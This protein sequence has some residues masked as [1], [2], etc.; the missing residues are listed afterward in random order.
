MTSDELNKRVKGLVEK[1]FKAGFECGMVEAID[2]RHDKTRDRL[3]FTYFREELAHK[4]W[5][6]MKNSF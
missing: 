1:A 3:T 6:R 4:V 2:P 5:E